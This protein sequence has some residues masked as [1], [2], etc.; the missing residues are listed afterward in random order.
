MKAVKLIYDIFM[1][2]E[3]YLVDPSEQFKVN[4]KTVPIKCEDHGKLKADRLREN[5]KIAQ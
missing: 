1:Q 3:R 2:D 5:K 4:P